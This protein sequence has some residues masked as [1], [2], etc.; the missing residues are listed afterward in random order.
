MIV[1]LDPWTQRL[2][3]KFLEVWMVLI[4]QKKN[5][6]RFWEFYNGNSNKF[7]LDMLLLTWSNKIKSEAACCLSQ[8]NQI[9]IA[10]YHKYK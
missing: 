1:L 8:A 10:Y 4:M 6:D 9:W 5:Q 7:S 3:Q 2:S